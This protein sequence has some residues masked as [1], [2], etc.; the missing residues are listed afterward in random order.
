MT[1]EPLSPGNDSGVAFRAELAER[2]T[3]ARKYTKAQLEEA[4]RVRAGEIGLLATCLCCY[5]IVK[6]DTASQHEEWC[7]SEM[8]AQ[9][10]KRTNGGA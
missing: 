7:V 6:V 4:Y 3:L 2:K 10:M 8:M 9:S 5:P 1:D